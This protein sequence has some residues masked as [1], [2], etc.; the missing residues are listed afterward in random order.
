MKTSLLVAFVGAMLLPAPETFSP[1][2]EGF[3]RN[4]LVL[5]PI[6]VQDEAGETLAGEDL[7]PREVEKVGAGRR[8]K[9]AEI[10]LAQLRRRARPS[11]S[12]ARSFGRHP[13]CIRE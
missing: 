6:A 5:A 7:V 2:A 9:R 1:D 12:E 8:E 4:W 13:S 10:L 3:I 11:I